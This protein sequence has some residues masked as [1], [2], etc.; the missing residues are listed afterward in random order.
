MTSKVHQKVDDPDDSD[1]GK[2]YN[3]VMKSWKQEE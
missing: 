1:E 3:L 2:D